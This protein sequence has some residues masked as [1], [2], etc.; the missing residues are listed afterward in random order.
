[1]SVANQANEKLTQ[2]VSLASKIEAHLSGGKKKKG[3]EDKD[4]AQTAKTT[5]GE[6]TGGGGKNDMSKDATAIGGLSTSLSSLISAV[7]GM[8]AKAGDKLAG[9]ITKMASSI[10]QAV[11]D[12]LDPDKV[13]EIN[14]TITELV[15]GSAGF[16]KDMAKS[17]LYAIPGMIGAVFFGL[18]LKLLL[19]ILQGVKG[20]NKDS[21]ESIKMILESAKGALLFGL[22]MSAYII[23][24]IPAMIGATV[25]G[26]TVL[27]LTRILGKVSSTKQ[28]RDSVTSVLSLAK[29]AILF[30]LAMAGIAMLAPLVAI[31]ALV[32]TLSVK[33]MLVVFGKVGNKN[34]DSVKSLMK[35][36]QGAA[37][38][39]L[40]MV[41]IGYL[42]QP[43]A[44]GT[45]V[46]ILAVSA[47]LLIFGKLPG[48]VS[49][50]AKLLDLAQGAA[51]FALTMVAI[52]FLAQQFAIGTLVF[53][54]AVSAMLLVFSKL[55]GNIK[56]LLGLQVLEKIM[57]ASIMFAA[58]MII[59]GFFAAP[60]A[61]GTLVFILAASAMLIVFGYLAKRFPEAERGGLALQS[62]MQGTLKFAVS[63][64]LIGYFAKQFAIG[65]I[66]FIIAAGSMIAVFG[67]LAKQFPSA[68]K[69]G[70]ALEAIAKNIIPFT[71]ALLIAGLFPGKILLGA[72]AITI[73]ILLLGPALAELQLLNKGKVVEKGANLL[74]KIAPSMAIFAASLALLGAMPG[75]GPDLFIKVGVVAASIAILGYA[76]F[77]LGTLDSPPLKVVSAGALILLAI[78]GAMIIF[79]GAL[80]IISQAKFTQKS[81]EDLGYT[82]VVI[83]LSMAQIGLLSPFII[84]GAVALLVA[85]PAL[86]MLSGV[87]GILNAVGPFT[88]ESADALGYAIGVIGTSF[89]LV[90]L[91]IIPIILG[92][93]A[94]LAAMPALLML[95][96]VF[97]IL[98]A[99]GP[100]TK[101]SADAV[102]YAIGVIGTSFALAGMSI[103]PI[104]LGSVALI[105]A[106]LSLLTLT[107]SLATFK[108]IGWEKSDGES[109]A[110]ALTSVIQGF[111]HALDGVGIIGLIKI[112]TA[113]PLLNK[114]GTS[115][116]SLAVGI[117]AMATLTF[118][119]SEYDEKSGKLVPKREVRLTNEDIQA[120]G[121]NTA[122]ILNALAEPLANF[123]MWSTKGALGFGAFV[124]GPSYMDYGIQYAQKIGRVMVSLAEGVAKMAKLEIV[125][126]DVINPGTAKAKIVPKSSRK[127]T[128]TD[129]TNAAK[130]VKKILSALTIP[131]VNFGAAVTKGEGVWGGDGYIAKGIKAAG[132]V[133]SI[134]ADLASGVVKMANGEITEYTVFG[135]GTKDAKL[136][137]KGVRKIGPADFKKSAENVK[138]ILNS[139]LWP[140]VKFGYYVDEHGDEV[141]AGLDAVAKIADPVSKIADMV[142]KMAGGQATVN[143]LVSDG[144]GGKKLVAKGL[145]NFS[146]ALPTAI[147]QTK[148]LLT[149]MAKVLIN[150]GY[151]ISENEDNFEYA[152][153]FLPRFSEMMSL[154]VKGTDQLLKV[155]KALIEAK[156][157]ADKGGINVNKEVRNMV[158][159]IL[160]ISSLMERIE[161]ENLNK[162]VKSTTLLT[163]SADDYLTITKSFSE[164]EKLKIDPTP[165]LTNFA[166][167]ILKI[168]Q[169]FDKMNLAKVNLY[170]KFTS[171]TTGLTKI[172]TPF[173]K[174]VK[175]FGQF[176][177]DMSFF[178]KTWETFGK[179]NA[180]NLKSYADS[181]KTIAS[182]DA[183]KLRETTQALKEQAIAQ[184]SLNAANTAATPGPAAD[185]GG[186]ILGQVGNVVGNVVGAVTGNKDGGPK[187]PQQTT[188]TPNT[189]TTMRVT[190]LY[191]N[192]D[193]VPKRS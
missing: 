81:A 54:L 163:K 95:S 78:A 174:F 122:A 60:F 48:R 140:I 15:K 143:E 125:D 151:Y 102:G 68:V 17:I 27:L 21:R 26:L 29:G 89:A 136:V 49:G 8:S 117:K 14:E 32:F 66:A 22:A 126:Y 167:S 157:A 133:A 103:I 150:F 169:S 51:L 134:V 128:N 44:M 161:P 135:A 55:T 172:I 119:E 183:S 127:L 175:L 184:Q 65:T 187:Q 97:G 4:N 6:K 46:F 123:G 36:A 139:L 69:G 110:N 39:T 30:A 70:Q 173:E 82:I 75:A 159:M 188:Q 192:G 124:I 94:L 18:T 148:K 24:G 116:A 92:S 12:G 59:I 137:P 71:F 189:V 107:P 37:L 90:G 63:M 181:L 104:I 155:T 93:V 98:N 67:Y 145:I 53:I 156:D 112:M 109:L 100:F 118:I 40:T 99:V 3:V 76:A 31:G 34:I 153:E 121:T 142:L 91:L 58:A 152:E 84:L 138:K 87:F 191:L 193:L 179:D 79:A 25:F 132:G 5:K 182:V 154:V 88:K 13:K 166:M 77:I 180:D 120:V 16:M 115:L 105:P 131:L 101:D 149:G 57:R 73:A 129:F 178:V 28:S 42:A 20:M 11:K 158:G 9:F 186:T 190:N 72:G 144:K 41:A 74:L 86:L 43:F 130:N 113:I 50:V 177:K 176:G 85:M 56:V 108:S 111:A 19:R 64:I 61:M 38:F 52:G 35:L 165:I 170:Q 162:V 185:G 171:I 114:I 80:Y 168:G 1:M 146:T 147:K 7:D 106:A 2:L 10:K 164:A 96:G 47:M 45:V 62:M 23:I 33:L 141:N 160:T 83:G